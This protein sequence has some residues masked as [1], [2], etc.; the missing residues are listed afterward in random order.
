M[1]YDVKVHID[2]AKPIGS[3]GFGMPLILLENATDEVAYTEVTSAAAVKEAGIAETSKAYK[4]AQLIFAQTNGPKTIAVVAVSGAATAALAD[5]LLTDKG[6][7]QLIVVNDSDGSTDSTVAAI[8][9]IVE[10]LEGKMYFAGLDADDTT[11]IAV[12]GLS[13]TVLFYCDATEDAPV[14]V[15]ALVGEGAG[16]AAGSFTYKNMILKGI[17]PQVL[18]DAEIDAIHKKGGITFVQKA[19]D[20]VTSEGK[21]AGGEYIDIIDCQD[22]IILQLAYKTQRLLNTAAKVPY[23]NNGIAML[24]SV[25]VDVLQGAYNNGMIA[26]NADG[27]PAYSVSYALR[28]DTTAEDRAKRQYYGGAF[29]FELAGAI[30]HVEITG[31]ITA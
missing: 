8:S 13:R 24:E 12:T 4:A 21:T 25:A 2:L 23:D 11:E 26:N 31:E 22:Y 14:P 18:T 29:T 3:L 5:S 17:E 6:W 7:R 20:N 10:K 16:R 19:G 28:E 15:A 30:H 9:A 1:A 27:S